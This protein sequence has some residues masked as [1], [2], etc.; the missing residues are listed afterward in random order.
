MQVLL[1]DLA[2]NHPVEAWDK[3]MN[4]NLNS[5]FRLSKQVA[6]SS[7]IPNQYGKIIILRQLQVCRN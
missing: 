7:M 3:V 5:V 1:G 4:L 2:E 6:V